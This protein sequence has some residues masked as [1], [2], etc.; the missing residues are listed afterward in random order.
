M[1]CLFSLVLGFVG[2][3]G[4]VFF[5]AGHDN[6]MRVVWGS[7]AFW[8]LATV[9]AVATTGWSSFVSFLIGG[10]VLFVLAPTTLGDIVFTWGRAIIQIANT[11]MLRDIGVVATP[12]RATGRTLQNL[13]WYIAKLR[14]F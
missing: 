11:P 5:N 1:S 14:W 13:Q 6:G 3:I 9:L 10:V 2:M 7:A 8:I 12:L 4:L